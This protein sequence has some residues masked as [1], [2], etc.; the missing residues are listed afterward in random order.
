MAD[1]K[2]LDDE[3]NGFIKAHLD[4]VNGWI[5][6]G[7]EHKFISTQDKLKL[8]QIIVDSGEIAKE[9][10]V[11][12][13]CLGTYLGQC[14]VDDTGWNWVILTDEYGTDLAIK[15]PEKE[16]WI[17]PCT[18]ISKRIEDGETVKVVDLFKKIVPTALSVDAAK[19][20]S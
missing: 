6:P 10:T 3:W 1:T 9:E 13:Q 12:L 2:P 11:K 14:I 16:A 5:S 4:W 15:I 19:S 7:S 20:S 17:F 8:L 18:L